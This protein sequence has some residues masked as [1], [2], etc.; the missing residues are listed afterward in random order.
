MVK[1]R[2]LALAYTPANRTRI[3]DWAPFGK[4]TLAEIV[5]E[6]NRKQKQGWEGYPPSHI[7]KFMKVFDVVRHDLNAIG[8]LDQKDYTSVV[9]LLADRDSDIMHQ[10]PNELNWIRDGLSHADRGTTYLAQAGQKHEPKKLVD[11]FKGRVRPYPSKSPFA[12]NSQAEFEFLLG[13]FNIIPDPYPA[14]GNRMIDDLFPPRSVVGRRGR[15][16]AQKQKEYLSAF[17]K[18]RD[19][20]RDTVIEQGLS[21]EEAQAMARLATQQ[22][23]ALQVVARQVRVQ[24]HSEQVILDTLRTPAPK[25]AIDPFQKPV[26]DEVEL[27]E[28]RPSQA[29]GDLSAQKRRILYQLGLTQENYAAVSIN[30]PETRHLMKRLG[31]SVSVNFMSAHLPSFK[32]KF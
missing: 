25:L 2:I 13:G 27:V 22:E 10:N 12:L 7:D 29:I 20:V 8:K 28:F 30:T 3:T 5:E 14:A 31:N 6:H 19:V 1:E 21:P 11:F 18:I 15:R 17:A 24:L 4:N 32:T 26:Y 23:L 9:L 16:P